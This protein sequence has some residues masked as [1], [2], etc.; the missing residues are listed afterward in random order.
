MNYEEKNKAYPCDEPEKNRSYPCDE[1]AGNRSYPCDTDDEAFFDAQDPAAFAAERSDEPAEEAV[2]VKKGKGRRGGNA[3]ASMVIHSG[4]FQQ[5]RVSD[6]DEFSGR[7]T[8]SRSS[9]SSETRNSYSSGLQPPLGVGLRVG[10]DGAELGGY[11][12]S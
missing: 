12:L 3:A 4:K 10:R 8:D 9:Y 11:G 2:P 7:A 1:P 6:R 5:K